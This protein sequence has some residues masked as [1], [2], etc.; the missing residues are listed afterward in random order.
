MTTNINV[1]DS[2][3]APERLAMHR[4]DDH[5]RSLHGARGRRHGHQRPQ[6][7]RLPAGGRRD[8]H[9]RPHRAGR[10][11]RGDRHQGAEGATAGALGG[12]CWAGL[13]GFLVGIGALAIPGI[14][15]V[16]AGGA[17]ATAFGLGAGPPSPGPA[18][19][20]AAGGI[21]GALVGMGIPEEEAKHFE[22]GFREGGV[23]VTVNAGER[24]MDALAILER[25]GADTGPGSLGARSAG[26]GAGTATGALGGRRRRG[27]RDGG[28][29]PGGHRRRRRRR[30]DR[31]RRGRRGRHRRGVD[32]GRQGQPRPAHRHHSLTT[33]PCPTSGPSK[34]VSG[35]RHLGGG[36]IILP[37]VDSGM[38]GIMGYAG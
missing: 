9:A 19:A 8:R 2:G 22:A 32:D 23:L 16:V 20:R 36:R 15:P 24:A 21:V 1:S 25:N 10:A 7:R 29:R 26:P 12:A 6:G 31:G 3:L 14:G 30:R 18:S 34:E 27:G 37:T 38:C 4:P 11:G 17:L 28:R 5:R 35:P 33:A 13:V